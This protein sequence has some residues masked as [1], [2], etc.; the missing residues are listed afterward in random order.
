M[1]SSP[2]VSDL[3]PECLHPELS[4][5]IVTHGRWELTERA[6]RALA[7]HTNRPFEVIVVDN[8]SPD[9][10]PVRL[11]EL[12]NLR[13]IRNPDNRGFGPANN[14]G[15]RIARGKYL[16]LL[17][18]DA[19]VHAGW[20]E[21]LLERLKADGVGA[22]V[23]RY[24]HPDGSLQEAGVLV[25]KDGTVWF[26]GDREDPRSGSVCFPRVVDSASAACALTRTETFLG[27]GGFDESFAGA[28]YEDADFWQRLAQA[29][30][31]VL[32]EPRS[33]VTHVRHGSGE[34]RLA[35]EASEANRSKFVERWSPYLTGR[36]GT[37]LTAS[38]QAV[39]AA[40]DAPATPRVLLSA[41]PSDQAKHVAHALLLRFPRARITWS[42]TASATAGVAAEELL[43]A[44]IEVI[45]GAD[46]SWLSHRLF[47]YD[48]VVFDEPP[49]GDLRRALSRTQ[50]QAPQIELDDLAGS[51]SSADALLA[52]FGIAA[53]RE[54]T[55]VG[56]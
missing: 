33:T 47:L 36:P 44:G 1:A 55:L 28:Y 27:L 18:T 16:L 46:A 41:R 42:M 23:P 32:Y 51:R 49:D 39:F 19:F 31:A 3:L 10:T 14:Q 20:L 37:F 6:L 50:P 35:C 26:Y 52:Q 8:A 30:Q 29:G 2:A 25:A 11:E 12:R 48:L 38:Q 43:E 17:N 56:R 54:T 9:E 7:A 5:L 22:V 15:A 40:R 45:P 13:V 34:H 53:P 21:P 4:V 24:L